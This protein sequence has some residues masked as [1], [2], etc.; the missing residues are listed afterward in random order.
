M[1]RPDTEGLRFINPHTKTLCPRARLSKD[2][3]LI[4]NSD[5]GKYMSLSGGMEF[6]VAIPEEH[7]PSNDNFVMYL[8]DPLI[9]PDVPTVSVFLQLVDERDIVYGLHDFRN[10]ARQF[11]DPRFN[12]VFVDFTVTKMEVDTYPAFILVELKADL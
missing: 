2:G 7:C 3:D 1:R 5:A 8:I 9:R 4:L 10:V 12:G 6:V 11:N